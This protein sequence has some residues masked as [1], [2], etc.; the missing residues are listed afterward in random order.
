MFFVFA[1]VKLESVISEAVFAMHV[2]MHLCLHLSEYCLMRFASLSIL[3]LL[4]VI[5]VALGH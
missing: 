1:F 5:A 2:L 3:N 4:S